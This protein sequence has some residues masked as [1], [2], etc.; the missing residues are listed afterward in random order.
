[1]LYA[2]HK[3]LR[4]TGLALVLAVL[5]LNIVK[6]IQG[7]TPSWFDFWFFAAL[8]TIALLGDAYRELS[9]KE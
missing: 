8:A 4:F 3:W 7:A 5:I 1:M 2:A 6:H 9:D